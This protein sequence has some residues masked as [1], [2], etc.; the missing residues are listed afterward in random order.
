MY[1]DEA[2]AELTAEGIS[3]DPDLSIGIMIETP[4]AALIADLLAR[5]VDFFSVGTNDLIQYCLAVD[6]GNEHVAYL[7]EPLHPAILRAL[8]MICSAAEKAGISLG[9]CGEMAA[10]PLYTLVLLGLGFDELSMNAPSIPQVKRILRQ[11]R[12]EEGERLFDDLLQL[13][14]AREV[15]ARLESEMTRRFPEIFG[16]PAI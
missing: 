2:K 16:A 3:F 4:A 5:E 7:Y 10:E 6:R 9:M 12:R 8:K 15:A 11:V 1:L 14:T 13:P